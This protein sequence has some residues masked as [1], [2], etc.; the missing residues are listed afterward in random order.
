M[1]LLRRINGSKPPI[2]L[3]RTMCIV[4]QP[5]PCFIVV[6]QKQAT[7]TRPP[8]LC[9]KVVRARRIVYPVCGD[10]FRF[11]G[12]KQFE[13][14]FI[15]QIFS[16]TAAVPS[17]IFSRRIRLRIQYVLCQQQRLIIFCL[18]Y[19]PFDFRAV[20]RS[21]GYGIAAG[22]GNA[23]SILCIGIGNGMLLCILLGVGALFY[24]KMEIGITQIKCIFR[25][26]LH[27]CRNVDPHQARTLI[28]AVFNDL[29]AVCQHNLR[30]HV[31][32]TERTRSDS[33]NGRRHR[34]T[35]I[36]AT[37]AERILPNLHHRQAIDHS[38][39]L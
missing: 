22:Q 35:G 4:R 38:W 3:R 17:D 19:Q 24:R 12:R 37:A 36:A 13:Q 31:H 39:Q 15:I 28:K 27:R 30:Q 33:L 1:R 25:N 14:Q 20:A 26:I 8:R 11:L 16:N 34:N 2:L 7:E 6:Q 10:D 9:G 5:I 21:K 29:Y 18:Q 32:L 23:V